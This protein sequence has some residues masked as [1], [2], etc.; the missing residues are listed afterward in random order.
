MELASIDVLSYAAAAA[1]LYSF[2]ARTMVPLRAAA[3]AANLFFIVYSA[4]KGVHATL[5]LHVLLLPLNVHRLHAM[6]KL[7]RSVRD[8]AATGDFSMDWLRS[9]MKARSYPAGAIMFRKGEAADEAFA[10]VSGEILLEEIGVRI[11]PGTFFGEMGLF[12]SNNQRTVTARCV[13]PAQVLYITY[14]EF[15]QLYFQQP[16]FGFYVLR[17]IVQRMEKNL[18]LARQTALAEPPDRAGPPAPVQV[19]EPGQKMLQSTE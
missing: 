10:L 12:T 18:E 14:D 4:A 5:V 1:T 17:L 19:P 9:Y 8:A 2:F 3:I 6:L 11:G 15:R 7:T 13:G 16:S